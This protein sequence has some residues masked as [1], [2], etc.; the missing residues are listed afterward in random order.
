MMTLVLVGAGHAHAQ[1]LLELAQK[2]VA[3]I[4]IMLVAPHHLAP[5]SGMLPGWLAGHYDWDESCI[6]FA[7]LC[8]KS[9]AQFVMGHANGIDTVNSQ[10]LLEDGRRV[11]YDCLSL[12]I[13]STVTAPASTEMRILPMRPLADLHAG[14]QALIDEVKQ[15]EKGAR[16]RLAMI[17]GGAAGVESVLAAH[18][19][20]T[21][22]APGIRLQ[23]TLATSTQQLVP[24]LAQGAA[25]RLQYHLAKR[26]IT[27]VQDFSASRID[28]KRI[29]SSSGKS[30]EAD[31]AMWATGAEAH[32]WPQQAGLSCDGR[33]FIQVDEKLRS[34][35]HPQIFASGDCASWQSPLPKA[36]VYAVR[37]GPV[38]ASNL[39]AAMTGVPLRA[40]QPQR[41]YLVMIGTGGAHAVA[42]RGPFAWQGKWVWRWKQKIDRRFMR[43]YNV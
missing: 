25:R 8:R 11:R 34:I 18:Q 27:L 29:L 43:R 41:H 42:A 35:S 21:Q 14:W 31:A 19:R 40:Y 16:F 17:G 5:Y 30:L 12:N 39:R 7:Y 3:G 33:G 23:C 6:D 38:L 13:G 15:S 20:L 9:G 36:G 2:P 24:G 4:Q 32:P 1:V 26:N 22:L 10:L 37:M 28:R